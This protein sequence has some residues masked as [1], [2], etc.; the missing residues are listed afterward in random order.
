MSPGAAG[1]SKGC[2]R[3][4]TS[5]GSGS[6]AARPSASMMRARRS[7]WTRTRASASARVARSVE[8][9]K[10]ASKSETRRAVFSRI[11]S[12]RAR[13]SGATSRI[14]ESRSAWTTLYA[15]KRA[16]VSGEAPPEPAASSPAAPPPAATTRRRS[17]TR[18]APG[19]PPMRDASSSESSSGNESGR[20]TPAT[21]RASMPRFRRGQPR[22]A[23]TSHMVRSPS[24]AAVRRIDS[25]TAGLCAAGSSATRSMCVARVNARY[26]A[27]SAAGPSPSIRRVSS[28]EGGVPSRSRT[29]AARRCTLPVPALVS[30]RSAGF[31]ESGEAAPMIRPIS[32]SP[33]SVASPL[34]SRS[35]ASASVS[36][37][38][39]PMAARCSPAALAMARNARR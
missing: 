9:P 23:T 27:R 38:A 16:R 35:A 29:R 6:V 25:R 33:S 39:G 21:S 4:H 30:R 20:L 22:A 12:R 2:T 28:S 11:T 7:A 3:R 34:P 10:S 37:I 36:M 8:P 31:S 14:S 18:L 13:V 19:S 26:G 17:K 15:R 24:A 32:R 1:S 5:M